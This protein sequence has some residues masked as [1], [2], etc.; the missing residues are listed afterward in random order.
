MKMRLYLLIILL[1]SFL[2]SNNLHIILNHDNSK[3]FQDEDYYLS[4]LF[5]ET[6]LLKEL[7]IKKVYISDS[8]DDAY[9]I[10]QSPTLD[11][12][13]DN[14]LN[15]SIEKLLNKIINNST[16]KKNDTLIIVSSLDYI[17]TQIN[18]NSKNKIYNDGWIT[19]NNSPLKKLINSY[20]NKPLKEVNIFILDPNKNLKYLNKRRRFFSFLF[21][22]FGAK[23]LYY[24][25]LDNDFYRI[26][27]YLKAKI[28]TNKI[29]QKPKLKQENIL[30]L[31]DY[32][33][34]YKLN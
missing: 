31:N 10:D 24:G 7:K 9:K 21:N 34:Q 4:N 28:D 23:L 25:S 6:K 14:N 27:D 11:D 26:Y 17:N 22:E 2:I 1:Q 5:Y 16:I 33:I 3:P 32:T 15:L 19:S 18:L 12:L 20:S 30:K 29:F 8:E 13:E